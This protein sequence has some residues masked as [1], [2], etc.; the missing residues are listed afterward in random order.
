M[1][2]MSVLVPLTLSV[3][4]SGCGEKPA[5]TC[6]GTRM[7]T[8]P[9]ESMS[10]MDRYFILGDFS[11]Y[12]GSSV[13]KL[14]RDLPF[15]YRTRQAIT[16]S[17]GEL[18]GLAYQFHNDYTIN[19]SFAQVQYTKLNEKSKRWDFSKLNKETITGINVTHRA[20]EVNFYYC[21]DFGEIRL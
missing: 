7:V 14:E 18:I 9:V 10:E 20:G 2:F 8:M 17:A 4:L 5:T 16:K 6:M 1:K 21:K 3:A 13:E 12:L 19:L 15:K 11:Q